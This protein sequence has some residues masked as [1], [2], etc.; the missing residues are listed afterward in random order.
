MQFQTAKINCFKL[1]AQKDVNHPST[2]IDFNLT[3][4]SIG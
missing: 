2:K 4:G 1:L 3:E